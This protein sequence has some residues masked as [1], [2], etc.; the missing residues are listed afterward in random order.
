M[1]D[2]RCEQE[3]VK[4]YVAIM[5]E[6][7]R[8]NRLVFAEWEPVVHQAEE[9]GMK[10]CGCGEDC[11]EATKERL[12]FLIKKKLKFELYDGESDTSILFDY[13]G[14]Q[15][16][17]LIQLSVSTIIKYLCVWSLDA[18]SIEVGDQAISHLSPGREWPYDLCIHYHGTVISHV[19]YNAETIGALDPMGLVFR[20][21]GEKK[22]DEA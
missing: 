10:W 2:E 9:L 13:F 5:E 22:G 6:K 17:W 1:T 4:A 15:E 18:E 3:L 11:A 20:V 14:P 16:G 8:A 21:P 12:S 7:E 19:Y